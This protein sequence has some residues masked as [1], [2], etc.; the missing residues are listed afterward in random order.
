MNLPY[1]PM[2]NYVRLW[3]PSCFSDRHKKKIRLVEVHPMIIHVKFGYIWPSGFREE[4]QNVNLK[5]N[6][7]DDRPQV[8]VKAHMAYSQ[9]S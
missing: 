3:Q 2:I 5:V 6:D 8:M 1:G 9:V 4:E 7:E